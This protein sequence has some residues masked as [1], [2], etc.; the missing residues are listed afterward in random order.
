AD[1]ALSHQ[2]S[3]DHV[4]ERLGGQWS[5]RGNFDSIARE[6]GERPVGAR[7]AV[8]FEHHVPGDPHAPADSPAAHPRVESRIVAAVK[9]EHGVVFADPRS[10]RL[11]ELP[12]DAT[13]IKAMPLGGGEA[14]APHHITESHTPAESAHRP[15][16]E[17]TEHTEHPEHAESTK[18]TEPPAREPE[19]TREEPSSDIAERLGQG[20]E[21]VP[22]NEDYLSDP[23]HRATEADHRSIREAV[24]DQRI[25]DQIAENALS[26][27]DA[28]EHLRHMTDEGAIAVHGY[29]RGEYSYHVNEANRHGPGHPGFEL[30]QHNSRAIVDG[31]A[32]LPDHVGEVVRG[33]DVHG[34]PHLAKLTADH[35][36]V[37]ET[38]VEPTFTSASIKTGEFSSSKFGDDVEL[39]IQSK[40]GKDVSAL[41]ENPGERES[42]SRPGTQLHV[43]SKELVVTPEGKRKWVIHAEEVTPGDPRHL[44][45]ED[46]RRKMAERRERFTQEAPEYARRRQNALM[47]RLGGAVE[48]ETPPAKPVAPEPSISDRLGGHGFGEEPAPHAGET[49][50][51]DGT[52]THEPQDFSSM[53]RP[54]NPPYEAAIHAGT[55]S[56][57]QRAA[58]VRERHP[59]LG[60]VNPGFHQPGALEN[61]YMSNCTRTPE[62]YWDR[63]HG[64]NATAEPIPF[65]QMDSRGTLDHI[66]DRFGQKF[67]GRAD[68][69]TVIREMRDMPEDHH[70]VVAVKYEDAN[71]VER[72]HVAM[73]VNTRDGVAFID[74]QSGDLLNLPT[75]PK[76]IRLMHVGVPDTGG[77]PH[78]TTS[79]EQTSHEQAPKEPITEPKPAQPVDPRIAFA[80]P[81]ETPVDPRIAYARDGGPHGVDVRPSRIGPDGRP[82][83][84]FTEHVPATPEHPPAT[85]HQPDHGGYGMAER[86]HDEAVTGHEHVDPRVREEAERFLSRPEVEAAL[87]S[88][89]SGDYI[90]AHLAEHPG[91][92]NLMQDPVNE[93]LTRSLLNNPKTIESLMEHPEAIPILE[94]AAHEAVTRGDE[95]VREVHE[96][97]VTPFEPTREQ[98]EIA[99]AAEEIA[100]GAKPEDRKHASFLPE[101]RNNEEATKQWVADERAN[102]RANQ[103]KLNAIA[104]RL[105]AENDGH[106]GYRTKPKEDD[107]ALAKIAK[108]KGDG[109]QLTDLVG[110]K[111]QFKTVADLYNALR[112]VQNDPAL[113]IVYFEDRMANPKPSGYRDLQMNVQLPN[114]H[115]AELRLHLTHID[116]VAAYEHALFEVR[117]DFET[118]SRQEGRGGKLSPEEAALDAALI[119]QLRGRFQEALEQGLPPATREENA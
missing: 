21:T 67:S 37:G 88:H 7:T 13:G 11:A 97:G 40:T 108:Y 62:A 41:A 28:H 1:G 82:V 18:D 44:G 111:V 43:H 27:R 101:F 98:I 34:D 24:G 113:K 48:P 105:A 81:P 77:V 119:E 30:A 69:D 33:I 25:Y 115:V 90:R 100:A 2:Q 42:L 94:T 3:L 107:R 20:R 50:A 68:Y 8:A 29:T 87:D 114:K 10:G 78:T 92:L 109:G 56:P 32:Q 53:A 103:D 31:L 76:D 71:G 80:K 59:H 93:T 35:Y 14:P 75:P 19:P 118:L 64:G 9:T 89:A 112:E 54:T 55:A 47:E 26:R 73:V 116:D 63:L 117:R 83:P 12:H 5:D 84:S 74:P 39:H 57:E 99:E 51:H 52:S 38:T 72:G 102:W 70:A 17:H 49:P 4:S 95:L 104:D 110:A 15:T 61:G 66:E 36:V 22:H 106:A 60:E 23:E 16:E 58:Y 85:H 46:A 86:P 65:G 96:A 6:L 45:P 79:H 91:L